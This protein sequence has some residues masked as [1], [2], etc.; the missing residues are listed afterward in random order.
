MFK[1]KKKKE[2]GITKLHLCSCT[3]K[4]NKFYKKFQYKE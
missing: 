2:T 1:K 3:I 4:Q